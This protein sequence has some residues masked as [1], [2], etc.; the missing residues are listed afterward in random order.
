MIL[1]NDAKRILDFVNLE[2]GDP[3]FVASVGLV[4]RA[5][6]DSLSC[7]GVFDEALDNIFCTAFDVGQDKRLRANEVCKA[8]T[9]RDAHS[10]QCAS[11]MRRRR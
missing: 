4:E 3:N 10:T 1:R 2:Y 5:S 11:L 7:D 8:R 9:V 6:V